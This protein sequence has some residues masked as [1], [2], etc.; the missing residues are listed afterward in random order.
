MH[1]FMLPKVVR[2][3]LDQLN[4]GN[5]Q[6]PGVWP[7]HYQPFQQNTGDLLLYGFSIGLSKERQQC[8][9]EIVGV[10]IWIAKLVGNSIEE[11]IAA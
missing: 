10:A 3:I 9:A 5:Q 4:K 1:K 6:P 11:Q 7:V 8:A 2:R